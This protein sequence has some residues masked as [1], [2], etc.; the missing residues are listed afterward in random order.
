MYGVQYIHILIWTLCMLMAC[1]VSIDHVPVNH[2][3]IQ[4]LRWIAAVYTGSL[5]F[6]EV[7]QWVVT[8]TLEMKATELQSLQTL[9]SP[10]S[11]SRPRS[12][13]VTTFIEWAVVFKRAVFEISTPD[14]DDVLGTYT[15]ILVE[16]ERLGHLCAEPHDVWL[17][18]CTRSLLRQ[19]Q[20][21]VE[22]T[23]HTDRSRRLRAYEQSEIDLAHAVRS[24][25]VAGDQLVMVSNDDEHRDPHLPP[26]TNGDR[27]TALANYTAAES[28]HTSARE[29]RDRLLNHH[30][31]IQSSIDLVSTLLTETV[32]TWPQCTVPVSSFCPPAP[33]HHTQ[34]IYGH[35]LFEVPSTIADSAARTRMRV[36]PK[37]ELLSL[38]PWSLLCTQEVVILTQTTHIQLSPETSRV[39]RLYV[40]PDIQVYFHAMRNVHRSSIMELSTL[41]L[42]QG[43]RVHFVTADHEERV[44]I[45]WHHVD[46]VHLCRTHPE[47]QY[48]KHAASIFGTTTIGTYTS[49]TDQERQ[50]IDAELSELRYRIIGLERDIANEVGVSEAL[51]LELK[52]CEESRLE[53]VSRR[54]LN[55][56]CTLGFSL[57]DVLTCEGKDFVGNDHG[58]GGDDH[59]DDSSPS[60]HHGQSSS[61]THHNN[62]SH[63]DDETISICI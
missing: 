15:R 18:S 21:V 16:M 61:H 28:S 17:R 58:G 25:S 5:P 24:L 43:S 6:L 40:A 19:A 44:L 55:E 57:W 11:E 47:I 8:T 26:L 22:R 60:D 37:Q 9:L 4:D 31:A 2:Q 38:E 10:V 45:R 27:D 56:V 23:L 41:V 59:D 46:P 33:V 42:G 30:L 13:F 29:D 12:G 36:I 48:R 54:G 63:G 53:L 34:N 14:N 50:Q 20:W 49:T 62:S 1:D 7:C 52:E 35:W 51:R 3:D 39:V 32:V